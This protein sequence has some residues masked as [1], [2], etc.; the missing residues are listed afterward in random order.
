MTALLAL[1]L[2]VPAAAGV[3]LLRLSWPRTARWRWTGGVV[4]GA[5][6]GVGLFAASFFLWM[7]L[8]GA[9][10]MLLW[11]EAASVIVLAALAVRRGVTL[12][13]R[14]PR[15][16]PGGRGPSLLLT[17]TFA[18]VLAGAAVAFAALLQRQPHGEWDA[19]MNWDLR[20][21]M[22]FRGGDSWWPAF[23]GEI[24][25]SH[26]DYPI[27]VPSTVVRSWLY[28][29]RE[30]LRGPALVAAAFTFGTVLLLVSALAELRSRTHGLLAG[31]VLLSTPFF[32]VHGTSLYADVP[33]G[34][35]F[36]ATLVC[37]A[38]DG[39]YGSE[40][41]R[42]AVL[43]GA[44]AGLAMWTKNEGLL[45]TFALI[46]GILLQGTRRGWPDTRTRLLAFG[47][48]AA[49]LVL[50]TAG[51]K[52]AFAPPNDLLSTLGIERTLGNLTDPERYVRTLRAYALHVPAFGRNEFGSGMWVLV[53]LLL[54]FG[55]SRVEAARP[56]LRASAAGLVLL[57]AGH[58]AVF[59]SM[60]HELQRLLNSSLDRLLLQLWP[61]L[62]FV[63]FS[64][65]A[66][67]EERTA[68]AKEAA[69]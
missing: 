2:L 11:I 13:A 42:F 8:F 5:G 27:L 52:V 16:P 29:G 47:A 19:W 39:R 15:T 40:T 4:L 7:L 6:F 21:R 24:P 68:S 53:A 50:L 56:W 57:L 45:F 26:P 66:T 36:L 34:F 23:S 64:V 37:L 20:A 25:W 33:L 46:G 35:Y 14:A 22:I 32:I 69:A 28:A 51:F 60:A 67:L 38:L 1:S 44:A 65:T 41:P 12:T 3:L 17:A 49:P 30:T 55:V 48:G 63:F 9:S 61:S 62:L 18:V 43:A 31:V 54:G 58:F 10:R 59:V